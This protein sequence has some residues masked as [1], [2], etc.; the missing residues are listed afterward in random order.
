MGLNG[1]PTSI[2]Q[3]PMQR[4]QRLDLRTGWW[5][6]CERRARRSGGEPSCQ[7]ARRGLCQLKERAGRE[8][9]EEFE[10]LCTKAIGLSFVLGP[11]LWFLGAIV[12]TLDIGRNFHDDDSWWRESSPSTGAC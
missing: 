11:L 6:S 8:D 12:Y 4:T 5:T 2:D 9:S 3:K 10:R 7:T 1:T